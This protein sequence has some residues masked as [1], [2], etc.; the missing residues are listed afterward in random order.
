MKYDVTDEVVIKSSL[1][2]VFNAIIDVYDGKNN[3]WMPSVSSKLSQ[4]NS[5]ANLGSLYKVT[6]HGKPSIAFVTKT[7]EIKPNEMIRLHYIKGAYIGEGLWEFKQIGD[8]TKVTFRWRTQPN[9]LML[10]I[11]APF[12]PI[13][14]THSAVMQKGFKNLKKLLE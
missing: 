4:V 14:K 6:I 13:A 10:K 12:F 1:P 5:S 11:I 9:I 3:W 7:V 8:I 2:A